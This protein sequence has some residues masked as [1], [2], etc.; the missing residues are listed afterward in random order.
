ME[1]KDTKQEVSE[2]KKGGDNEVF[3]GNLSWDATEDDIGEHFSNWGTVTSVKILYTY[4]GK[5]KGIAFVQ[6]ENASEAE[7]AI[8]EA[9]GKE[10]MDRDLRV[11]KSAEK[12]EKTKKTGGGSKFSKEETQ[13]STIVFVGNLSYNSDE[14]ALEEFFKVYGEVKNVRV[15]YD[16]DGYSK[17]FAHVE[18]E[19]TEDAAKAL[20]ANGEE[21]D[22][23]GLRLDL[24]LPKD[25]SRPK[26]GGRGRGRGGRGRGG[27]GGGRGKGYY[28]DS[29]T[30]NDGGDPWDN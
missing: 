14:A 30:N 5:S 20:D 11:N 6:Y 21:L 26:R 28:E 3:V 15:G 9:N 4:S 29:N 27:R 24:S 7:E 2:D 12:P 22:G 16:R 19:S 13:D 1:E 25:S 18:F 10:W 17:G 23:R 8:K